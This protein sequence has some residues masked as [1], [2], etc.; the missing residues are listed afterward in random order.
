MRRRGYTP[1]AIRRFWTEAGVARRE[2]NIEYA[3]L[4]SVLRDDLNQRA[5]RRMAVLRPLKVV[6]TNYPEDKSE[7]MDL[8][9]NPEDESE[10]TRQVPFG[11]EIYIEQEDFM[12]DPPKKFYRLGPGREVRLRNA[13]WI[14]C[15]DF[16]KDDDGNVVELHCTYDPDTYG[17][18]NPPPDEDGNVRKVKGTLHWVPAAEAIDAEVRLYDHLFT[19][20]DPLDVPDDGNWLDNVNPDSLEVLTGCKLEPSLAELKPGV[21]VQFERIGYFT[22]DPDGTPAAPVFNRTATL[23]DTWAKVKNAG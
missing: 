23:R 14:T 21:P 4:E 7:M 20:E 10:G 1:Q 2:N 17:G 9:N 15:Q 22:A 3:K 8:V 11:R 19:V 12:E 16:V 18:S 6:I 13:Y 5:T